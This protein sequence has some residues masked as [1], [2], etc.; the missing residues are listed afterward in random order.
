LQV[1][2]EKL[3]QEAIIQSGQGSLRAKV[4]ELANLVSEAVDLPQKK[5]QSQAT[6]DVGQFCK[7]GKKAREEEQKLFQV[8][9]DQAIVCLICV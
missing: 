8:K 2:D 1:F 4:E 9:V 7:A 6:L 5:L 3:W